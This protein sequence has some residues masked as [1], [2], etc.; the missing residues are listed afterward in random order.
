MGECGRA[1]SAAASGKGT[2]GPLHELVSDQQL[3][4]DSIDSSQNWIL[5]LTLAPLFL[6]LAILIAVSLLQ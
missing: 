3:D 4:P 5:W 1:S 6:L 2:C